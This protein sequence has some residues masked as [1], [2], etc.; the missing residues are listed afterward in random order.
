MPSASTS[1]FGIFCGT[2]DVFNAFGLM[3]YGCVRALGDTSGDVSS[4]LES[5]YIYIYIYVHIYTVK[6]FPHSYLYDESLYWHQKKNSC[7]EKL[8]IVIGLLIAIL[9]NKWKKTGLLTSYPMKI[10]CLLM[11]S[12]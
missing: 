10:H 12:N 11:L 8:H 6:K 4:S 1:A 9:G 3:E 5:V 7:D 2:T